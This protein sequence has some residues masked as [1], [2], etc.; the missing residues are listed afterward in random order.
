MTNAKNP[1]KPTPP[2]TLVDEG[3]TKASVPA[4]ASYCAKMK[5]KMETKKRRK[6]PMR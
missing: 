3:S 2:S 5:A 4:A 6:R 1:Q